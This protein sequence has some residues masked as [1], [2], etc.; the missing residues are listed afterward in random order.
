MIGRFQ[1]IFD[2][3]GH[4]ISGMYV[5]AV[6]R[7]YEG[8]GLFGNLSNATI[9]NVTLTQSCIVADGAG[10]VSA[11]IGSLAGSIAQ[12][13]IEN[14]EVAGLVRTKNVLSEVG[15][16]VGS[17]LDS[18]VNGC[19]FTGSI[20]CQECNG[21]IGGIVGSFGGYDR[22]G[23]LENCTSEG[24]M[25]L[26]SSELG[27]VGGIVGFT[28]DGCVMNECVN[29]MNL[30]GGASRLGGVIGSIS[31]GSESTV[32]NGEMVYRNGSFEATSCGNYGSVSN[33]EKNAS[34]GG[35][36]GN[37]YNSDSRGERLQLSNLT[38]KGFVSGSQSVGGIIGEISSGYLLYS[39]QNCEN[40]GNIS[41]GKQI[42]GI[43]GWM[44]S[45]VDGCKISDCSNSG[46]ISAASPLGGIIGGY[47]GTAIT[48][49]RT[50]GQLTI[51]RC[52]NSGMV[53]NLDG[54]SGTGGILGQIH[55]DSES[56]S[57]LIIHCQNTG[58]VC[59]AGPAW[60]GGILGGPSVAMI[61]GSWSIQ[62][63]QNSGTL[64]IGSGTRDFAKDAQPEMEFINSSLVDPTSM[65]EEEYQ[66][67]LENRTVQA[68]GGSCVGGIA[69]KIWLGTIEDCIAAGNIMLDADAACYTGGIC[70]QFYHSD[71]SNSSLIRNCQYRKDW[72]IVVM[73]AVGTLENLPD[74]AIENVTASANAG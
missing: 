28:G 2:G 9:K 59:S 49:N 5:Y 46:T 54:I 31:I 51:D 11:D 73:P 67:S 72:P 50:E 45:C 35:V 53:E 8:A 63:C 41:G 4:T 32:K 74:G 44:D 40:Q 22:S 33:S 14:C 43:V 60:L 23:V 1:G 25:F 65:S 57:V 70:G 52:A 29:E 13:T 68:L 69:G 55:M 36:I 39:I 42:G 27:I 12:C 16:V 61:G 71:D 66:E 56:E 37:V 47:F 17:S 20:D 62:N 10:S 3:K 48:T 26:Q 30:A 6:N 38:N 58:K 64:S 34:T 19:R 15:G 24:S 21:N 18:T 7:Q